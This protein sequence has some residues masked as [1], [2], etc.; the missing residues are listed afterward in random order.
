MQRGAIPIMVV[1]S[2]ATA[3]QFVQER[4]AAPQLTPS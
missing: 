2:F 3:D 1:R 4:A